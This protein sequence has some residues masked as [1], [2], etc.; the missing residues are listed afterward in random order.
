VE[1]LLAREAAVVMD[2]SSERGVILYLLP[3]TIQSSQSHSDR[4][5]DDLLSRDQDSDSHAGA[6]VA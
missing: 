3:T 6:K 4:E 5:R 1:V 2:R